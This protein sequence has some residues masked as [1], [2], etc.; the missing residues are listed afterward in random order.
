MALPKEPLSRQE[1]YLNKIA[2]GE[3]NL[4]TE[5]LSRIEQYLSYICENGNSASG[6]GSSV[7]MDSD[8]G[9][10][11]DLPDIIPPA[12]YEDNSNYIVVTISSNNGKQT[13]FM[14]NYGNNIVFEGAV[15][16]INGTGHKITGSFSFNFESVP[17]NSQIGCHAD[18]LI[19]VYTN[20]T[21][22]YNLFKNNSYFVSKNI[23]LMTNQ[24]SCVKVQ[25]ARGIS[26]SLEKYI[27]KEGQIV[28]N[29]DDYS[30]HVMDGVKL[31]GY[32][33]SSS[34]SISQVNMS[35]LEERVLRLENII[36][37]MQ[38]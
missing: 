5:P 29:T 7:I 13:I 16:Y 8:L 31:G 30:I 3:G 20:D 6:N 2:T 28:V 24:P 10:I 37:T 18:Y 34:S 36:S 11:G 14:H 32:K 9:K 15:V 21:N 23:V 17:S 27:G 1:Q 38:V 12:I 4:P 35:D 22:I 33:I 25:Q 19:D 26:S